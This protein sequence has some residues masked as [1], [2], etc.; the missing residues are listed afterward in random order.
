M[1]PATPYRVPT[2][3][4]LADGTGTDAFEHPIT[5]TARIAAIRT[6]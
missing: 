1:R 6:A 3:V 4:A 2:A 5:N